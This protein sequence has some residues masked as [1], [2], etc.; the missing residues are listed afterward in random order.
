MQPVHDYVMGIKTDMAHPGTVMIDNK[1]V[2]VP[3]EKLSF[4]KKILK[5]FNK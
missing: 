5:V 3:K 2:I 1:P 4:T